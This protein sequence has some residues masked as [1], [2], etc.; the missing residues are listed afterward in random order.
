VDFER[1]ARGGVAGRLGPPEF[2]VSGR[3]GEDLGDFRAGSLGWQISDL[4]SA[5]SGVYVR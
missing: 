2:F 5:I 3:L 4:A 1:I